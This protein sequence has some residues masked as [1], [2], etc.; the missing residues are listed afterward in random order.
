MNKINSRILESTDSV[1]GRKGKEN[2]KEWI[3][4]EVV[5]M[6]NERR[7]YKNSNNEEDEKKYKIIRNKIIR[8]VKQ[9]KKKYLLGI[10]EDI[11]SSM[12]VG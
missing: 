1:T 2:R 5:D 8:K 7:K 6:I 11:N 3:S 12:E 9:D 10:C 4:Q